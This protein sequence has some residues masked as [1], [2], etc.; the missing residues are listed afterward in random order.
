[1]MRRHLWVVVYD[2]TDDRTRRH[3]EEELHAFGDRVQF[4]VFECRFTVFEARQHLGRIAG[5]MNVDTD[6]LRAYPQCSW[7]ESGTSETGSNMHT[8]N[9]ITMIV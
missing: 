2:V 5:A 8:E 6:S 9:P 4:S 3:I 1:M 7:C